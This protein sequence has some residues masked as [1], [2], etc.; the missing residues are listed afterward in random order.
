MPG[1]L[2]NLVAY[3]AQNVILNG[4]P[5][6][7]FFK[8]TY[9]KYSN[10]GMQKF[11]IDFNGQRTLRM[12]E[13][14][15]FDFKVPRYADLLMD[16]Y[17]VVNLPNI[18][19]PVVPPL[20]D[21]V[22]NS[23][24][25]TWQPFEF[26]WIDNIGSQMIEHVNFRVGGQLIQTLSGQYLMNMVERDFDEAKKQLYYKMTGN[27]AD[28]NDPANAQGRTNVYPNA[29]VGSNPDFNTAGAEPSIRGRTLYIPLNIWFTLAAKMAFPLISLQYAELTI[30]VVIRPVQELYRVRHI[31]GGTEE[32]EPYGY[33]ESTDPTSSTYAFYK[34]LQSP[35]VVDV[36][37]NTAYED[38]RTNWDSDI[39]LLSTYCFLSDD[40]IRVFA[41]QPQQYLIKEVYTTEYQNVVGSQRVDLKSIGMV[42]SYMWFFQRSDAFERNE[43][44]N[45]TNWAYAGVKPAGVRVPMLDTV[46]P[47]TCSDSQGVTRTFYPMYN[48]DNSH[49]GIMYT[50][51]ASPL[52]VESIMTSWALLLD[53]KYR[54]NQQD[55]GVLG[56]VEK[57]VR[58]S[59]NGQDGLYCYNF[60]LN[61]TPTDF[62]PS[63]AMNM[64]PFT[65]VEFEV[66]T[67]TPILDTQA[68]FSTI[69][70]PDG[71]VIGTIKPAWGIYEYTF[72]LI[73]M[74]ERFNVLKFE[75]G[76]AALEFA[77]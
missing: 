34:F 18:W 30:E 76:M 19:S 47:Y 45:Y 7:T 26:R 9:A 35:P 28:L 55:A 8:T 52:N 39:H 64:S 62:Q 57:Y 67:T 27:V 33:Y 37:T 13:R 49:T 5:Q 10:F 72:N 70:G 71:V 24:S 46:E 21:A 75:S 65:T 31:A 2:L 73:V 29:L 38:R 60:S 74:E 48:V 63:G 59:G 69:C 4:N 12:T 6:K 23:P 3:G 44:S 16:T 1:G 43:W 25:K 54:E 50:G 36:R 17:L 40:E 20:C 32:F 77:R 14:S 51:T 11:R 68:E 66:S 53:G 42:S 41:S 58:T 61:T 56:Y 22:E 15:V